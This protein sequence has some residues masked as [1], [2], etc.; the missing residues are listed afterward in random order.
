MILRNTTLPHCRFGIGNVCPVKE[1]TL[2]TMI[3]RHTARKN[4]V[5]V[6][7][8]Q[9]GLENFMQ[10][11]L[12]LSPCVPDCSYCRLGSSYSSCWPSHGKP[13]TVHFVDWGLKSSSSLCWPHLRYA[14]HRKLASTTRAGGPGRALRMECRT[15]TKMTM[16]YCKCVRYGS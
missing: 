11:M 6:L 3:L 5:L 12:A 10:F 14:V 16:F 9:W 1:K 7:F 13:P 4:S 8:V 15:T 2:S